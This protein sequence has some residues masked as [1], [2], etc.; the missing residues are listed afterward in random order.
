L[1]NGPCGGSINGYCEV[2]PKEKLCFWV[3]SYNRGPKPD[4]N[5]IQATKAIPPKDWSLNRT[6]SWLNYFSGK[7]H[8]RIKDEKK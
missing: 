6:S 7:D 1:V 5:T 8:C 4:C 2:Y 3:R